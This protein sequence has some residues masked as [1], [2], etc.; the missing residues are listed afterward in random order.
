MSTTKP[1]FI[2]YH[3]PHPEYRELATGM[4]ASVEQFDLECEI[5]E[6]PNHVVPEMHSMATWVSNCAMCGPF[7]QWMQTLHPDR[8][9]VY[10]DV[11]A[12]LRKRPSLYL[13]EPR[14]YD[15]AVTF[16]NNQW[17]TNE[18]QSNSM[19]FK[20]INDSSESRLLVNRWCY[21]QAIRLT[22]MRAGLYTHPFRRAWDQV[23]LQD[24]LVNMPHLRIKTLP[25]SYSKI[26][27]TS[28]GVEIMPDVA[29]ADA[30]VT[31]SQASRIMKEK[32]A[33]L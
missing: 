23:V 26:M 32:V 31:Q 27:P 10:L 5:V 9:L 22:N 1:L 20:A 16:L 21:E 11:D 15:F 30:V 7:V 19:F 18:L 4:R 6:L 12:I 8:D 14:D 25:P 33:A 17:S 3:T 13:D 28:A 24:V 29:T 2:G